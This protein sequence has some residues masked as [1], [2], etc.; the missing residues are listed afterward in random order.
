MYQYTYY[1]ALLSAGKSAATGASGARD[2]S[3]AWTTANGNKS[4]TR[5][6]E[7]SGFTK[8][9]I[10]SQVIALNILKI[11]PKSKIL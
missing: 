7:S 8:K 11:Y 9:S 5:E 10:L 6:A 1:E 4:S 2:R 3:G